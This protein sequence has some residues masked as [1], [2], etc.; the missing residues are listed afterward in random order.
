MCAHGCR[1][2][3]KMTGAGLR[4][5]AW[6]SVI[7]LNSISVIT[8]LPQQLPYVGPIMPSTSRNPQRTTGMSLSTTRYSSLVNLGMNS[9]SCGGSTAAADRDGGEDAQGDARATRMR[10]GRPEQRGAV[11]VH[12]GE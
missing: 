4:S 9:D 5:V 2:T 10:H 12:G 11:L 8:L 3:G 1:L 7:T 6:A